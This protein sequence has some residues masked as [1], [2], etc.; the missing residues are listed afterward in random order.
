MVV[1]GQRFVEGGELD[2]VR[3]LRSSQS[4]ETGLLPGRQILDARGGDQETFLVEAGTVDTATIDIGEVVGE[5]VCCSKV[6]LVDSIEE[7][8]EAGLVGRLRAGI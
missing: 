2:F 6:A 7:L 4:V 5:A 1:D 8:L 3:C